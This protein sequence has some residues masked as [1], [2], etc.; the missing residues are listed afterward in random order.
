MA[1]QQDMADLFAYWV[2]GELDPDL[3]AAVEVEDRG[4]GGVL[5]EFEVVEAAAEHS[6]SGMV[7]CYSVRF[8]DGSRVRVQ[9]EKLP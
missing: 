3:S 1:K 8:E 5:G 6:I 9:V 4:G 7:Q 2:A